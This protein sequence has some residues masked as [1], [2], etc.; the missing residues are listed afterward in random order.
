[1]NP[2][3]VQPTAQ[4]SEKS[5][6]NWTIYIAVAAIVVIAALVAL[7]AVKKRKSNKK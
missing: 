6:E 5:V 3:A 7:I 2:S 1:M 4:P